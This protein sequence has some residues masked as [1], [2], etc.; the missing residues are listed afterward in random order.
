MSW[1]NNSTQPLD[2]AQAYSYGG[3]CMQLD[4]QHLILGASFYPNRDD[5]EVLIEDH[6]HNLNLL[7]SVFPNYAKDLAPI[8]HWQGR[9]SVRAQS[10][11]YFPLVGK[12]DSA[13]EI[14]TFA[15]LGSKG[16]LFAPLC[17]E[18]LV[19]EILQQA[20][21]VPEK[22]RQKL[23]AKRFYKQPKAKKPYFKAT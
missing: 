17:S 5:A 13:S 12:L 9:A 16:F 8:T 7:E 22:L 15:G 18:V 11:D 19:A 20:C 21:P 14:Y 3:Y 6:Q 4:S 23:Q 10:L 1:L 2:L